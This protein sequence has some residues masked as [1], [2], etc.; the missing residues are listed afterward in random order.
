MNKSVTPP[1][2]C[3][4]KVSV[5]FF[6][7][8]RKTWSSFVGNEINWNSSSEFLKTWSFFSQPSQFTY[9][10]HNGIAKYP[11]R[12]MCSICI[13]VGTG[14]TMGLISWKNHQDSTVQSLWNHMPCANHADPLQIT[15]I[16]NF[17]AGEWGPSP[18]HLLDW[19]GAMT[20]DTALY[21][22]CFFLLQK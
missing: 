13:V 20:T 17:E 22:V 10:F 3:L 16:V 4:F 18:A 14:W 8:S 1:K 21:N 6:C 2:R 7:P 5:I 15:W 19:L 9:S 11:L 12:R